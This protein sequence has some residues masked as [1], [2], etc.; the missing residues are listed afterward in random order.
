MS[1]HEL[2][3]VISQLV[4]PKEQNKT[5]TDDDV[6]KYANRIRSMYRSKGMPLTADSSDID[7]TIRFLKSKALGIDPGGD[8][9]PDSN[10]CSENLASKYRSL[11]ADSNDVYTVYLRMENTLLQP[12]SAETTSFVRH[13]NLSADGEVIEFVRLLETLVKLM[14]FYDIITDEPDSEVG[15]ELFN[16]LSPPHGGMASKSMALRSLRGA[17]KIPTP[18]REALLKAQPRLDDRAIVDERDIFDERGLLDWA[19][20]RLKQLR[21]RMDEQ[22]RTVKFNLNTVTRPSKP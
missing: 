3:R 18:D 16:E 22:D 6:L 5:F 11:L 19:T 1:I 7:D 17:L 13:R 10:P 2:R 14:N 12:R 4:A 21:G 8:T 15:S 20:A 9:A